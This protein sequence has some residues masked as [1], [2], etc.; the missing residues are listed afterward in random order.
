[1]FR[2]RDGS[3]NGL[4]AACILL[5]SLLWLADP[6]ERS[7]S[8]REGVIRSRFTCPQGISR[9]PEQSSKTANF[10]FCSREAYTSGRQGCLPGADNECDRSN[11]DPELLTNQ[12]E[13]PCAE[14]HITKQTCKASDGKRNAK[15]ERQEAKDL[16]K[17]GCPA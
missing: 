3:R 7:R 2:L 12:E 14:R 6:Q 15:C 13:Y 16:W 10:P 5:V 4:F 1:M 17:Y 11:E 9:T 8:C